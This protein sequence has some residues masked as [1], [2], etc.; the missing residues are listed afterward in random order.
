MT[1]KS[2]LIALVCSATSTLVHASTQAHL[3]QI[4]QE[5]PTATTVQAPEGL[6]L[7]ATGVP[8]TVNVVAT[9][10]PA[11]PNGTALLS[12]GSTAIDSVSI[13]NGTAHSTETFSSL[14]LHQLSVCYI[15]T[16]NFLPS[17]SAS[18]SLTV[19]APYV[20]E[21]SKASGV[22]TTAATFSDKLSV[23]PAKGFV[24]T[25]QLSCQVQEGKCDLSAT[26]LSFTGNSEPQVVNASFIPAAQLPP[27]ISFIA[28]LLGIIGYSNRRKRFVTVVGIFA[29]AILLCGL[30]GCHALSY[31]F[32]PESDSM[33]VSA[34]S[35]S[36]SQVASYKITV[37]P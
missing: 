27:S 30:A 7:A 23:I 32:V 10:G 28:P 16:A 33:A 19:L 14:G 9:S 21:Q 31:P 29:G 35:N 2:L 24:G 17:C 11:V 36:Y 20:L 13:V 26:S 18:I 22:I 12:D 25:V 34:K 4:V 37:N 15:G 1:A 3:V 6:S 5:A 8:L